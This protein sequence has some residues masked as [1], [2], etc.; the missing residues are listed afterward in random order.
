V[1]HALGGGRAAVFAYGQ[2]GAGK[3]YTMMGSPAA[4]GLYLSAARDIFA[5]GGAGGAVRVQARS[6][7]LPPPTPSPVP[8]PGPRAGYGSTQPGH[9]ETR[10]RRWFVAAP[11]LCRSPDNFV[12]AQTDMAPAM[13]QDPRPPSPI[14][15]T[16]STTSTTSSHAPAPPS[17]SYA[18]LYSAAPAAP[19]C[20]PGVWSRGQPALRRGMSCDADCP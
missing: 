17:L 18:G 13:V 7:P 4:P 5:R 6:S 8:S 16:T 14:T 11:A 9:L 2:T 10:P 12:A 15:S 19:T 20:Y 3:T 1:D